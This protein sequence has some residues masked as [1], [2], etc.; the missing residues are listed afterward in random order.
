MQT[1]IKDSNAIIMQ[2]IQESENRTVVP[3]FFVMFY[4][5]TEGFLHVYDTRDLHTCHKAVM[6]THPEYVLVS[7]EPCL[8]EKAA[9][10]VCQSVRMT[11][12]IHAIFRT[13]ALAHNKAL[14]GA[15]AAA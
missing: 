9:R 12:R 4:Y 3:R 1:I 5:D 14:P 6:K 11:E 8:D 2:T 10:S 7:V 15:A 13:A